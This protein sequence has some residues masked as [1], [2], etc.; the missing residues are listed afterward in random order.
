MRDYSLGPLSHVNTCQ[1]VY[2]MV[3]THLHIFYRRIVA[4]VALGYISRRGILVRRYREQ[5]PISRISDGERCD[6][7]Y[8]ML[9]ARRPRACHTIYKMGSHTSCLVAQIDGI[10]PVPH[11]RGRIPHGRGSEGVE[12]DPPHAAHRC[13]KSA[14]S[15]GH[16]NAINAIECSAMYAARGQAL[17]NVCAGAKWRIMWGS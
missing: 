7:D 10:S 13:P 3:L 12:R 16:A 6:G 9:S 14:R 8:D 17:S 4:Y 11:P 5:C 1:R 2:S 15:K